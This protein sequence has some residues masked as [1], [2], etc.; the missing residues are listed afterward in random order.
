MIILNANTNVT[1]AT[2]TKST[3]P[4]AGKLA[5]LVKGSGFGRGGL[6]SIEINTSVC[7]D[8]TARLTY[9]NKAVDTYDF[10]KYGTWFQTSGKTE[11]DT[12][13]AQAAK[14]G[15]LK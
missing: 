2:I 9:G 8:T 1:L 14:K 15:F 7:G 5:S 10:Q 11:A 3:A 6:V 13:R 12:A 4:D